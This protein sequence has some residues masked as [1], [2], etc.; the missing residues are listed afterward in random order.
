MDCRQRHDILTQII[1]ISSSSALINERLLQTAH[2]LCVKGVAPTIAIYLSEDRDRRLNLR[3]A[4][5]S[6]GRLQLPAPAWSY[7]LP[8]PEDSLCRPLSSMLPNPL[9]VR[10]DCADIFLRKRPEGWALPLADDQ[11]AYGVLTLVDRKPF[12]M[13]PETVVFMQV[14]CRQLALA[15]RAAILKERDQTKVR[16]LKFLHQIGARLNKAR[17]PRVVFPQ[18]P[19][20]GLPL[21]AD[22]AAFL[23]VYPGPAGPDIDYAYGFRDAA[24]QDAARGASRRQAERVR[25]SNRPLIVDDP[26]QYAGDPVYEKFFQFF[27][28]HIILP[29][30]GQEKTNGIIEFFLGRQAASDNLLPLGEEDLELLEILADH[31]AATVERTQAQEQLTKANQA[32]LLRTRQLTLSHRIKNALLAADTPETIIRLTLGALISD[33]GFASSPALYFEA[34]ELEGHWHGRFAAAADYLDQGPGPHSQLLE[35]RIEKLTEKL[36]QAT[37][38]TP[39]E[40]QQLINTTILPEITAAPE[41]LQKVIAGHR[42]LLI[43]TA[44]VTVLHGNLKQFF[45]GSRILVI[46][47]SNQERLRGLIFAN[48]DAISPQD[49]EYIT[50]F[51]DA[52]GLA[53]DNTD[54]FQRLQN[55]LAS[56]NSAQHRLAQSEKLMALGEMATSIAHE[57][58]NPL[59][60]IAGFAR[61][62][63]KKIPDQSREKTYSQIITKEIERL[64]EIVNNVL[65]FSKP[66]SDIFVP[67]NLNRL[68]EET[69]A[70]FSRQLRTAH[71]R[72]S[73]SLCRELEEVE[74]DGN[75]IKQ[76]IINLINNS[77]QA[78]TSL[79]ENRIR[80][81]KLRTS[82]YSNTKDREARALIEIEDNGDG[83]QEQFIHDIF[84]PF[85]TTKHDGTGLGLPICH[86]IIMNHQGEIRINNRVGKGVKVSISLPFVHKKPSG[87]TV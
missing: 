49:L 77:L 38:R 58:K 37:L 17:D 71:V 51:T 40:N 31:L 36:L 2:F 52:A 14:V 32:S 56:L 41:R 86:R 73:L 66:Q 16:R 81:L 68:I 72:L 29:L 1:A 87:P 70:L 84:N 62:L 83:I 25:F 63:H 53:L 4:A 50:L 85:F 8:A 74:G 42:P 35:S 59:V 22:A 10:G 61:R 26:D 47:L 44:F 65:S 46:P 75:Q 9:S 80:R 11:K 79:P 5:D 39:P 82:F 64:E 28:A 57:I 23:R 7:R 69:A 20:S 54:L 12:A 45:T 13:A 6:G 21:F 43:D 30:C 34:D 33:E 76:V 27:A 67:V 15:L 19:D 60:S 18:L 3:L 48:G 24:G 78:M 55:S